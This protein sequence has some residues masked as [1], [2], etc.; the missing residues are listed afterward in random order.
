MN[1]LIANILVVSFLL[2]AYIVLNLICLPEG[3]QESFLTVVEQL[4]TIFSSLLLVNL[5]L[6]GYSKRTQKQNDISKVL[7]DKEI[8]L[9]YKPLIDIQEVNFLDLTKEKCN[10]AMDIDIYSIMTDNDIYAFNSKESISG[11]GVMINTTP[12]SNMSFFGYNKLSYTDGSTTYGYA[13]LLRLYNKS[14]YG[15]T[16]YK[17]ITS[18]TKYQLHI[19]YYDRFPKEVLAPGEYKDMLVIYYF[20]EKNKNLQEHHRITFK[21]KNINSEIYNYNITFRFNLNFVDSKRILTLGN[22]DIL[23][24]HPFEVHNSMILAKGLVPKK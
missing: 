12:I 23:T 2:V 7:R 3:L 1:M 4:L 16:V 13:T 22:E 18:N 20:D 17:N 6:R 15:I 8:E 10:P 9:K 19:Y 14:E 24:F 5:T 11:N 21:V